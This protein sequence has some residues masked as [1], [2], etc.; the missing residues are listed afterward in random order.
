MQLYDHSEVIVLDTNFILISIAEVDSQRYLCDKCFVSLRDRAQVEQLLR[1][2]VEE[3]P[4]DAESKRVFK[5]VTMRLSNN[6]LF[7]VL[8][9]LLLYLFY[10]IYVYCL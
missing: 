5:Y 9:T 7:K 1:Y 4:E 8:L 3:P 10:D 2:I 6:K